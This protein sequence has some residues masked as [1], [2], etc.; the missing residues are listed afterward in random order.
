MLDFIRNVFKSDSPES[1]KRFFGAI[2]FLSAIFFIAFFDRTLIT[3]LLYTSSA[4]IGLDTVQKLGS[5]FRNK[6]K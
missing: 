2:G 6:E 4:L 5:L 3:E 1:S